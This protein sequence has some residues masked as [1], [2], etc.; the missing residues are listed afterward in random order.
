MSDL[1]NAIERTNANGGG[2]EYGNTKGGGGGGSIAT[3]VVNNSTGDLTGASIVLKY[4]STIITTTN[5]IGDSIQVGAIGVYTI[6]CG[7]Y[8]VDV[9]VTA[10]GTMVY[11]D[12]N[13]TDSWK[14]WV[15][16]GGLDP[17]DYDNLAEV[18]ADEA[19][20]RRLMTIHASVDF[21]A[22]GNRNASL[23]STIINDNYCAKWINLRD[24]AL[25][26]LYANEDIA[27]LMDTADKYF[28]GE[29]VLKDGTWGPKGN[30]P[31]MT[32][33]TAPY[34]E[35]S[36]DSVLSSSTDYSAYNVFNNNDNT[37]WSAASGVTSGVRLKYKFTQPTIVKKVSAYRM[38]AWEYYPTVKVQGS[39]D[40]ITWD[41]ISE[42]FDVPSG[43]TTVRTLNNNNAYIYYALY[44]VS[45]TSTWLNM[46]SLQFYGRE[47]KVSVPTMTSN[48]APY[49]E[50]SAAYVYGNLADYAA[51]KAFDGNDSTGCMFFSQ[52]SVTSQDTWIEYEFS[53]KVRVKYIYLL[54]AQTGNLVSLPSCKYE[55]YNNGAWVE[56]GN[57][58]TVAVG[59]QSYIMILS[60]PIETNAIR[61]RYNTVK[62][63]DNN[64]YEG[65]IVYTLNFFGFD[66]SEHNERHYIYDHGVELETIQYGGD[67]TYKVIAENDGNEIHLKSNG[68]SGGVISAMAQA[69]SSIDVSSYSLIRITVGR[70]ITGDTA[71][72]ACFLLAT[73]SLNLSSTTIY[74]YVDINVG[75]SLLPNNYGLD[76]SNVNVSCY[77]SLADSNNGAVE[78]TYTEWWLE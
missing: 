7:A 36:A 73:D 18:L 56:L 69:M 76:I 67:S 58:F 4:G 49:G 45:S 55:Y 19:A 11:A 8:S 30:V 5:H 29:W 78:S 72:R 48:T 68:G 22:N 28:Y 34:G 66:Y 44:F 31:V 71:L 38:S 1:Y 43:Q 41:D 52:A 33:D 24:Y 6:E 77:L 26:T 15:T 65:I 62:R 39:N 17:D 10:L 25:D 51:Y 27:D 70:K 54:A 3:I 23:I 14:M 12:V 53:E 37:C 61:L 75:S 63:S 20:L 46:T 40:N 35:A 13:T 57:S 74:A 64:N 21:L 9:T 42:A 59:K 50:A 16:A 60:E 2:A 32:S 47:M